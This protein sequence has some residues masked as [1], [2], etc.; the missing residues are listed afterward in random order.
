M[1]ER[2][3]EWG[4]RNRFLAFLASVLIVAG[5]VTTYLRLP[6]AAF[7]DVTPVQVQINTEAPGL[8]AVEVEQLISFPIESVMNGLPDVRIVRSSSKTGLSVVSV[9][10]ED[11]VDVHFARGLVLE[12]LQAARE[13]IPE[14]V[15]NPEMGPITTGMG[16]IYQYQV[17]GEGKSPQEL[18]AFN[19]WVVKLELRSV[20]GVTD[21]LSFGGEVRQYQVQVNPDLLIKYDL[22]IEDVSE[23]V[24]RNNSN[25]GGWYLPR[26][27]EQLIIRGVGRIR[28]GAQ[29][30]LDLEN[31]ILKHVEGVPIRVRDVAQ[32]AYG[33]E[34]RQ[35]AVTRNGE[36]EIVT[37]IVLQLIG[38]NTRK[39]IEGVRKKVADL[40]RIAERDGFRIVPYYDQAHLVDK[41]VGTVTNA[42][43]QAGVLV[44]AILFL[45][46]WNLRSA[47]VVICSIPVSMLIAIIMMDLFELS[48]N[49]QSLGG[50]A[51]GIGMIVDGSVVIVENIFRRRSQ[52]HGGTREA[53]REV[54]RPVFF[55]V[56]IIVII[57]LPLFTLQGVEGKLFSPMAFTIAFAMFGSLV[58]ALLLVPALC[59]VVLRGRL[60]ERE[61]FLVRGIKGVYQP[62]LGWAV[63]KPILVAV[64]AILLF[65][66]S[67]AVVPRLGTEF[68]PELEEGTI[69]LRVSMNPSISLEE[70]K[71]ISA[72]LE[73]KIIAHPE[74]T[75]AISLIGRAEVGGDP[76]PVSNNELFIGLKP[77]T[78]RQAMIPRLEK[79]LSEVPGLLFNFS[80]P[81]ATRVAE[82]MSGVKA[83]IAIRLFGDDL[84]ILQKEGAKIEE[85]IGK[86]DGATDV[87]MD[88]VGGEAQL[89]IRVD[90]DAVAQFGLNVEEVMNV[91]GLALGGKAVGEVIDGKRRFD[92]YVRLNASFRDDVEKIK[93]L[94]VHSETG[95][96][97]PL[98]RVA[99]VDVEEGPPLIARDNARRRVVVQ[100][101]VRGRDMGS[102]VAEGQRLLKEK[103]E[104]GLPAG[105]SITWGGQ[106]ENQQRAQE[107]LMVVVPLC[108]LLIFVLLYM[109]FSSVKIGALIILNVPLSL[110]GGVFALLLSGQYLSVPASIGFIA[111]FGVAVQNGVVLVSCITQLRREGKPAREAAVGA[112]LVRIRPVL[113]TAL[114][115]VFGLVPLLLSTG[116]GSEI[117]R[118]LAT[119]VVGGLV[120]STLLTLLVLPAIYPWFDKEA[121]Q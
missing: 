44:T 103:V 91:V 8:A 110:I 41:A 60:P 119:V 57:F 112:A 61:S 37:G 62:L 88:K 32:V 120:T 59:D 111:V 70:A 68:V 22:S 73:K 67:L 36:G 28:G 51:I 42:L 52:G 7:P 33:S 102:F 100:C 90:R 84:E 48:A 93:G 29:G 108:I 78:D 12:R 77:G 115:T 53:A 47:L 56:L 40:N 76:E 31:I 3:V 83:Q 121:S 79:D 75:Y 2:I 95:A 87:E 10:F 55:S 30:L 35:G 23:A 86:L 94:L 98:D 49:L 109:N 69:T 104:P 72:K 6:V 64:G 15:G 39:V 106:F 105:Y 97:I 107:T 118:P 58:V 114:T 5:G 74:V 25:A 81:I 65:V 99:S 11:H 14:G 34:I 54:A 89:V 117:Q 46:L 13:R 38:A 18:R 63:G 43:L 1:I 4:L 80:Q 21:V 27:E 85:I 16:Q 50:L 9:F 26:G 20:A 17:L 96:L 66:S 116:V 113:M 82:L 24:R 71:N 92:I 101:N 19:D 45:F